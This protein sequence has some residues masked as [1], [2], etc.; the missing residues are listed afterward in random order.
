MSLRRKQSSA[1]ICLGNTWLSNV[2]TGLSVLRW[3]R[4][5]VVILLRRTPKRHHVGKFEMLSTG[6]RFVERRKEDILRN[7]GRNTGIPQRDILVVLSGEKAGGADCRLAGSSESIF[8]IAHRLVQISPMKW[9][10]SSPLC[11]KS[12]LMWRG[13][14]IFLSGLGRLFL[15]VEVCV[16]SCCMLHSLQHRDY[17][18]WH[19]AGG[20]CKGVCKDHAN[21]AE[22]IGAWG[23]RSIVCQ[24][25]A[26]A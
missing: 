5:I 26:V 8:S 11:F 24:L 15:K 18:T 10:Y 4:F 21:P 14:L 17:L 20:G 19:L 7:S 3:G 13:V 23:R 6:W 12:Q 2:L 16:T 9:A 22:W 1:L 25:S